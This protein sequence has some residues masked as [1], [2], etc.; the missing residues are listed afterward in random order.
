VPLK[1]FARWARNRSRD[2][3]GIGRD[4]IVGEMNIPSRES[5]LF[6]AVRRY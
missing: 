5:E 3:R 4:L 2:E 1:E 6:R